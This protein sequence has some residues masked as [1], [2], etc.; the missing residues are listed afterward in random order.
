MRGCALAADA[1]VKSLRGYALAR[2]APV[3][4]TRR[5]TL[6]G[7]APVEAPCGCVLA[8]EVPVGAAHGCMLVRVA[9]VKEC[10]AARG[11]VG[12][13]G[14]RKEG[15]STEGLRMASEVR[16]Q[17]SHGGYLRTLRAMAVR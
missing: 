1:P 2:E 3:R 15:I 6:A 7:D 14:T 11:S 12:S 17:Q 13:E 4:A 16:G 8:R 10:T 5:C 9:D